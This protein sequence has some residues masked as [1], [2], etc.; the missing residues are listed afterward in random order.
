MGVLL[1]S[2]M[3]VRLSV[4]ALVDEKIR[5]GLGLRVYWLEYVHHKQVFCGVLQNK[6]LADWAPRP[7]IFQLGI[8][9]IRLGNRINNVLSLWDLYLVVNHVG[10]CPNLCCGLHRKGF[11]D[12]GRMIFFLF[13]ILSS[14]RILCFF[15]CWGDFLCGFWVVQIWLL[16]C[17]GVSFGTKCGGLFKVG[18]C[19]FSQI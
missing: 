11:L 6:D 10:S 5:I 12:G 4:F 19:P 17:V 15:I 16:G 7:C 2:H 3:H 13:R 8:R 9:F 18:L 1:F 14:V